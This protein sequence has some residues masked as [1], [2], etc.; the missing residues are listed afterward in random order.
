MAIPSE[1]FAAAA[2][3]TQAGTSMQLV[4]FRLADEE[5]GIEI[6]KVHEIVLLGEMTRVPQMPPYVKGLLKLRNKAIPVVDL[7]LRFGLPSQPPTDDTRIVVVN[8]AGKTVGMLVDSVSEVLRIS[9]EELSPLPPA[10]AGQGRQY[11]SASVNRDKGLLVLLD[12][13]QL[14]PEHQPAT[15]PC[16]M[17]G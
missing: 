8:A 3:H 4:S 10:V 14:L 16:A 15:M 7:R 5:Y 11:L 13:D 6:A 17:A 2:C 9:R 1:D 12:L